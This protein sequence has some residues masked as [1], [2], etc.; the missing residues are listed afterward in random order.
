MLRCHAIWCLNLV[1]SF[2]RKLKAAVIPSKKAIPSKSVLTL[3]IEKLVSRIASRPMQS[4]CS[5]SK[6]SMSSTPPD[7]NSF[8]KMCKEP[9]GRS[10]KSAEATL[11]DSL[12]ELNQITLQRRGHCALFAVKCAPS[13]LETE[14]FS[15][16]GF[17]RLA[18]LDRVLCL[19][20]SQPEITGLKS[21]AAMG[22]KRLPLRKKFS[23]KNFIGRIDV[24]L[25]KMLWMFLATVLIAAPVR[26]EVIRV[27]YSGIS[28]A[29]TP[30]WLAKEEGIFTKHGLEADL[31]AVRS[32]PI[33]VSA[34]VSNEVQFVRGSVSSM[35]TAAAQGAKL[36]IL[37]SLFAERA[38]YDFLVSPSITGPRD[39]RD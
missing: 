24:M 32:A 1:S 12:L 16:R 25:A 13:L 39:L 30:L 37:F 28:A 5:K 38:S 4:S 18:A 22:A 14:T 26:A 6:F 10:K 11:P 15:P 31:V 9:F 34:L 27:A 23:L 17:L 7:G 2:F 29:G 3:A 21:E 20:S 35:L 19:G 36:K 8:S 33:Q